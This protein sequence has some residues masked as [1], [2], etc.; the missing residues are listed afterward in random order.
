LT[1]GWDT[2]QRMYLSRTFPSGALSGT[3]YGDVLMTEI[4]CLAHSHE[5]AAQFRQLAKSETN[6]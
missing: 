3:C 4:E 2:I 1:L 5:L 6:L